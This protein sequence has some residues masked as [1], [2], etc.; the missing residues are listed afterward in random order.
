[1]SM[2]PLHWYVNMSPCKIHHVRLL[3]KARADQTAENSQ[4]ETALGMACAHED[5]LNTSCSPSSKLVLT[6]LPRAQRGNCPR[7]GIQATE[8]QAYQGIVGRSLG[9][10]FRS[11]RGPRQ[12]VS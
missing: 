11:I 1:M 9:R 6:K 4:G 12:R 2:T 5:L 10:S 3:L 7:H 8:P